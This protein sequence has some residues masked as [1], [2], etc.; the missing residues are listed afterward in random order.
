MS[1]SI[2]FIEN[3]LASGYSV[4]V[5]CQQGVSR[6]A[7]IVIAYLMKTKNW[8]LIEAYSHLRRIRSQVKPNEGFLRQLARWEKVLKGETIDHSEE[9]KAYFDS[10]AE[11][12]EYQGPSVLGKRSVAE[13]K[14]EESDENQKVPENN[15]APEASISSDDSAVPKRPKVGPQ[16]PPVLP[17]GPADAS[18]S[19]N[20]TP[21]ATEQNPSVKRKIGPQR[22]PSLP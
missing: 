6:S 7:T 20:V 1:C 2:K 14:N 12:K 15:S 5:H 8:S 21:N 22:P 13:E 17:S 10:L 3:G 18:S 19:D 11:R 9:A 4:L 16:R